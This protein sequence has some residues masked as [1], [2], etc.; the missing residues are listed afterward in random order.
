M[1][2]SSSPTGAVVMDELYVVSNDK[3]EVLTGRIPSFSPE[4]ILVIAKN[5][6]EALQLARDFQ[7]GTRSPILCRFMSSLVEAIVE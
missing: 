4:T 6:F 2:T 5:R 1:I 3:A 7:G